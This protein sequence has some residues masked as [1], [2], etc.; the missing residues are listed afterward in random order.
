M[1]PLLLLLLLLVLLLVLPLP[2]LRD[3]AALSPRKSGMGLGDM[4]SAA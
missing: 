4:A 1:T 2:L 3:L